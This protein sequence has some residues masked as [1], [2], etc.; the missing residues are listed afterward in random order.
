M[1]GADGEVTVSVPL[2]G[3]IPAD[4]I[5]VIADGSAS[6]PTTVAGA[7]LVADFDFQNGPDSIVLRDALGTAVDALG[8]GTFE[9]GDVLRG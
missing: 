7:D 2:S 9:A 1:N 3:T 8:Y 4:G 6:G 5:F